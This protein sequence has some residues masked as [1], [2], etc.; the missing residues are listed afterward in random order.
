[1][2]EVAQPQSEDELN[3]KEKHIVQH[4]LDPNSEEDQFTADKIK[5]FK[6]KADYA[7]GEDIAVYEA[8]MNLKRDV[9][10]QEDDD[11]DNDGDSDRADAQLRHRR[12]QEIKKKIIDEGNAENK[13]KKNIY[14]VKVGNDADITRSNYGSKDLRP[15]TKRTSDSEGLKKSLSKMKRAGRAELKY[16]KNAGFIQTLN[17]FGKS[18]RKEEAEID[19]AEMSKPEMKKREDIVK[20]MKKSISGFKDRYG[21]RWKSVMYATATKKAMGENVGPVTPAGGEFDSEET[22]KAYKQSNMK[23]V[24]AAHKSATEITTE[25]VSQ[26][27]PKAGMRVYAGNTKSTKKIDDASLEEAFKGGIVKLN[28]GSSV[29]LKD[30][31]AK[32]INSL[33]SNLNA[34]NKKKM[35]N[36]AMTDK[37]GFNEILGFA[38]EAI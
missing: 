31:D 35:L 17:D 36:V 34:Q 6:N 23:N 29:I 25:Q 7:K 11:V 1:M 21:D 13:L 5:K 32:L 14:T 27:N 22:H 28:D 37:H 2:S 26:I 38:R 16:G 15:L 8:N 24:K 33:I 19:E 3:F 10:G 12:H 20:G 18:V 4:I 9:P 30:T